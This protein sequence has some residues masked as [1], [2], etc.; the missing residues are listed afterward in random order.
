MIDRQL[1]LV[2]LFL[3]NQSSYLTSDE[4]ATY[5]NVSNR[6]ARNDIKIVN[7]S[8]LAELIISV[9]AKGYTLNTRVTRLKISKRLFKDFLCRI[10][11]I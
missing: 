3:N 4:I 2:Q 5:L 9:K 10:V 11:T 8:L 1:K 6:T 7:M